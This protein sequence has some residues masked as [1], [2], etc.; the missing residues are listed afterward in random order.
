[1]MNNLKLKILYLFALTLFG[2]G[3]VNAKFLDED[4]HYVISY[5]WGLIHKDAGEAT[6]SLRDKGDSYSLRLTGKTKPWADKFFEVR[7]TLKGEVAKK[8]FKP[9]SY[10]K[11]AHEDGKYRLDDIK[12]T[13]GGSVVGGD[14]KRVRIDKKGNRS[15]DTKKLT[16]T[17]QTFDMLSVFYFL[18]NIDYSALD[19]GE[20]VKATVFSGSKSEKLTIR[21]VGIEDIKLRNNEKRQAYHIKFR[22]TTDGQKKSSD[23]IDAWISTDSAHIPLLVT[24]SLTV[25]QVKCYYIG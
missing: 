2:T 21:C 20:V 8:G 13:Y 14:V 16:S 1:M 9:V 23:D 15:E 22:F 10:T 7:D 4:L 5:K 18:R 11:I 6:L 19:K 24:G 12:Y 17:G 3:F 25:G